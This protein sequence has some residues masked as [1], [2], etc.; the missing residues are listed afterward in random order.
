MKEM[1]GNVEENRELSGEQ[2][3]KAARKWAWA[4]CYYAKEDEEFFEQFWCALQNSPQIYLEFIHYLQYQNFLCQYKIAGY[5]V[6]DIMV[7]QMDHF[8]AEMDRGQDDMR[9]NGD[10]MLLMAFDTML[11]MENQPEKYVQ[12][13]QT[14]TGT[15]YPDKF[16]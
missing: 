11:K 13:M 6:V 16:R 9:Q 12:L 8:K 5:S 1:Q 10:K 14:E 15:D 2:I 7:W 4:L 3:E